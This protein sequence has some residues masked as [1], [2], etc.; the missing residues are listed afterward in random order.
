MG[1]SVSWWRGQ[2]PI[3]TGSTMFQVSSILEQC[4]STKTKVTCQNSAILKYFFKKRPKKGRK[5]VVAP[6][7]S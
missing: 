3:H 6:I 1:I 7:E 2:Q 4:L 5:D